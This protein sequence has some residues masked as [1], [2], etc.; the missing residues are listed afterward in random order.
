LPQP[1]TKHIERLA[2][3]ASQD[4]NIAAIQ[5]NRV[6]RDAKL[7]GL[8]PGTVTKPDPLDTTTDP[9]PSGFF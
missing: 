3:P 7:L 4:L 1:G 6:A 5:V 8:V 9:D 2:R